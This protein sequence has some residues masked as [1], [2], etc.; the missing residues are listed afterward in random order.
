MRS[1]IPQGITSLQLQMMFITK[2]D[3]WKNLTKTECLEKIEEKYRPQYDATPNQ[4]AYVFT[5]HVNTVMGIAL[6]VSLHQNA[7]VVH[8]VSSCN[9]ICQYISQRDCHCG[10]GKKENKKNVRR[11]C[12]KCSVLSQLQP[13]TTE[14]P[15]TFSA[16]DVIRA[17]LSTRGM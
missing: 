15:A 14:T 17:I 4:E 6:N 12:N 5:Q 10:Q 1:G 11:V 2:D 7:S 8:N 16:P 3:S 9:Q 13:T